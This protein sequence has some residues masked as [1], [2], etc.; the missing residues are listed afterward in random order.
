MEKFG[1]ENVH[2]TPTSVTSGWIEST[3]PRVT[4]S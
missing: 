2:S 4:W 1:G 3:Q